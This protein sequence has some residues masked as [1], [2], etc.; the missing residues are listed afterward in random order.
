M[1]LRHRNTVVGGKCALPSALLVVYVLA[2]FL[3]VA[4]QLP[5]Q[6]LILL[7]G[8]LRLYETDDCNVLNKRLSTV[9]RDY[10]LLV[11]ACAIKPT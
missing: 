11:A 7:L 1:V 10:E 4:M 6:L 9:P 3:D 2:K 8:Q 5:A